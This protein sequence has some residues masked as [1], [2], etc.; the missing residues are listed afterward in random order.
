MLVKRRLRGLS[1]AGDLDLLS[2]GLQTLLFPENF[3]ERKGMS[4]KIRVESTTRQKK[5]NERTNPVRYLEPEP[6]T[7]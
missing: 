1:G 4:E 6:T 3:V 7:W 2:E 5:E